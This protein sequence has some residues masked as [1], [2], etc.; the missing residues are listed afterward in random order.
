MY[1]AGQRMKG[2]RITL[3]LFAA[4]MLPSAR[5]RGETK[6]QFTLASTAFRSGQAIPVKFTC[7]GRDVSPP[8]Q[9]TAPPVGTKSYVLLMED[10]DAPGGVWLHWLVY[11]M[12]GRLRKLPAGLSKREKLSSGGKQGMCWGV[13]SF[14]RIGYQGPCPPVGTPHHYVFSLY[15]M[16]VPLN[17]P[18]RAERKKVTAAMEGHV[19][20]IA[21]LIGLYG[22]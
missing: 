3:V 1:G 2:L 6:P 15:A 20:G 5:A 21:R 8:L 16:D 7:D 11:D 10:T 14:E 19:L 17:L 13:D 22:R 4:L 18:P 12:P 9:W